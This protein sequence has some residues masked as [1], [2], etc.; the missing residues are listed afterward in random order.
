MTKTLILMRHAKAKQFREDAPDISRELSE[1]GKRSL[2]ATLP[3]TLKLIPAGTR[4]R[5]WSSPAERA[6]ETALIVQASC[7][8]RG[9]DA[10]PEIEIVDSLWQQD[11]GS[12]MESVRADESEVIL[13]T[14]H[15]PFICEATAQLTGSHIVFATGGIAAIGLEDGPH[16]IG[17]PSGRLLWFAQGPV[18]QRWRTLVRLER[19]LEKAASDIDERMGNFAADPDDPE[20]AHKL[21][22]SIRTLRSLLAFVSPWQ[23]R[24]Q[25]KRLQADLK[26]FVSETSRLREL[27]VFAQQTEEAEGMSP[28]TIAFCA[29]AAAEERARVV[30]KLSSKRMQKLLA[31][32]IDEAHD[33]RWRKRVRAHGLPN[34]AIRARFDLLAAEL[35]SDLTA[36]DLADAETTHDIRKK[37]KQVRYVAENF[38]PLIGDD[39][40]IIAET[41]TA[42]Q[43]N[44]G[45]ICDARVNIDVIESLSSTDLDEPIAWDL[46]LLRAQ[47][48]TFLYTILRDSRQ[49]WPA[50]TRTR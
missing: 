41:M 4:L 10:P 5:I 7:Q 42:H 1:A 30:E 13:A 27:D 47:N 9:I 16:E 36:I 35:K 43:D 39:A 45:E 21:R 32:V 34:E 40:A 31:G 20:T 38:E 29:E 37:A 46:A 33:V 11:F 12:F 24:A 28:A 23:N 26:A 3:E 2:A 48:E 50:M 6:I 18:S 14:G 25:N 17:A 49:P 8:R 19:K 44:L 22:V 15:N